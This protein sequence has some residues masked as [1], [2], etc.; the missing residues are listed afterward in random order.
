M[1]SYQPSA[2]GYITYCNKNFKIHYDKK[3]INDMPGKYS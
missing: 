1:C 2:A 3:G